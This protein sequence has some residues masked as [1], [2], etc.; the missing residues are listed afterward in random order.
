[1]PGKDRLIEV[2]KESIKDV[3]AET[4]HLEHAAEHPDQVT[5][6]YVDEHTRHA[7]AAIDKAAGAVK[8]LVREE[9]G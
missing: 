9:G 7:H 3:H 1:M 2:A 4:G 6:S 8:I 5:E